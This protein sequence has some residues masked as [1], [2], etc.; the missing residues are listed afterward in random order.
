M[1]SAGARGET[2]EQMHRALHFPSTGAATQAEFTALLQ[3]FATDS[4]EHGMT[5]ANAL[6]SQAGAILEPEFVEL[7]SRLYG[8]TVR[9][10][11]FRGGKSEAAR[12]EINRWVAEK[13][14]QQI[15][16]LIPAGGMDA[17][18]RLALV[19]AVHAMFSRTSVQ[20]FSIDTWTR[21]DSAKSIC[22]CRAS[23]W[24]GTFS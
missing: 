14:D 10:A 1:V 7:M 23:R 6:W 15:R 21:P 19:N 3:R 8:G 4:N 2:A 18:T 9:T 20:I 16:N 13:T 5:M 12:A 11:D 24:P 17:D 22:I